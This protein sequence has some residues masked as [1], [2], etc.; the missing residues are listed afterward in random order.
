MKKEYE[1]PKAEK[2]TFEYSDV[3]VAS[4]S[5]C[6]TQHT[7]GDIGGGCSSVDYGDGK[8]FDIV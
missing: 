6:K 1:F 3:V 8:T 7:V 5:Q 4:S 2:M